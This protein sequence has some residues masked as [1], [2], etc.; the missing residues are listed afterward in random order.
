[1]K[2]F[3]TEDGMLTPPIEAFFDVIRSY[4][5]LRPSCGTDGS[6]TSKIWNMATSVVFLLMALTGALPTG[7]SAMSSSLVLRIA[8]ASQEEV[9]FDNRTMG[10][11]V[12]Q[13][14][15]SPPRAIR[16]TSGD[17]VLFAAFETNWYLA[18]RN[19]AEL[20]AVCASAGHG[21]QN[22]D[23][24]AM[25]DK[26][27]I[28]ALYTKNGRDVIALGSHEY[29]G[30]RHP[31]QCN[32]LPQNGLPAVCWFSSI[33]QYISMGDAR[34]FQSAQA[35]PV[36]AASQEP[37]SPATLHRVGFFTTSNIIAD[38]EYLYV[39]IFGEGMKSQPRG[40][41]LFRTERSGGASR[42]LGWDGS[43]FAVDLS[44][45]GTNS[46]HTCKPVGGLNREIRGLVRHRETGK[47][48]AVFNSREKSH[49]GVFYA[50]SDDMKHWDEPHLLLEAPLTREPPDC[51]AVYRYPSLIDHDGSEPSFESVGKRAFLYSVK[52]LL[53]DCRP[54]AR[55]ITRIPVTVEP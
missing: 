21:A 5:S 4:A 34:H 27:W 2:E 29:N 10:C 39:L 28:Q 48:V 3:T 6:M 38:G 8:D 37:Y 44:A 14:P 17:I 24:D 40:V 13:F 30:A 31:G 51:K 47:F 49:S 43:D 54:T 50:V 12:A 15:D 20:R 25:D 9:L 42:W 32:A 36:V 19:W 35:A 11:D 1:M 26:Y 23:P 7:A 16:E 33:T 18:G 55:L 41:C 22:A 45:V 53:E 52:I 46:G